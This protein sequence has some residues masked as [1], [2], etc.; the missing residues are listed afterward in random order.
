MGGFVAGALLIVGV[1]A[2]TATVLPSGAD[3]G[4][5][6]RGSSTTTSPEEVFLVCEAGLETSNGIETSSQAVTRVPAG[7]PVP[8]GCRIG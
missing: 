8:P 7:T 4:G 3:T 2:G 1:T 5:S 6:T